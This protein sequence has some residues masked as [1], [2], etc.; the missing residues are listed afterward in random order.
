M[1]II[2]QIIRWMMF[3]PLSI[4]GIVIILYLVQISEILLL[5]FHSIFWMLFWL[6]LLGMLILNVMQLISTGFTA[7][8]IYLCPNRKYG[9]YI[10]ITFS[11][12]AILSGVINMWIS[13]DKYSVTVIIVDTSMTFIC[14]TLLHSILGGVMFAIR[15]EIKSE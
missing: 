2:G 14:L 10:F 1:K 12:I 13:Q 5:S 8:I 3:L 4:L 15:K 6:S 9:G 11:V 7:L